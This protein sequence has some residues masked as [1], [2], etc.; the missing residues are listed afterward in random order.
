MTEETKGDE[1][2]RHYVETLEERGF[3]REETD[4][5]DPNW[6]IWSSPDVEIQLF[7]RSETYRPRARSKA[8][9]TPINFN[10]LLVE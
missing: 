3:E 5:P 2:Y 10:N 9:Q 4:N 1:A 7:F 8:T 6:E